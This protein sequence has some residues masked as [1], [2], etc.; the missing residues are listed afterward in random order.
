VFVKQAIPIP[1]AVLKLGSTLNTN[2]LLDLI[3][4]NLLLSSHGGRDVVAGVWH[5]GQG[6][7]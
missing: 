7:R 2:L 6:R 4:N 1:E 5:D 3:N